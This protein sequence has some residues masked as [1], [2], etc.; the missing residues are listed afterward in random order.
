[1]AMPRAESRPNAAVRAEPRGIGTAGARDPLAREVKLLGALLGQV[2]V[3]QEGEELLE[4]VER[5]RRAAIALRRTDSAEDRRAL[6]AQLDAVDPRRTE[7]LIRAFGL[8][9]QL[10]N[11]AEEKERVRRLRRR[12]RRSPR[13]IV[14]GSVMDAMDRLRRAGISR[15]R[16]LASIESLSIALVLTAHP[17]EARRRTMLMALRRCYHLLEQLDDPRLTPV[18]DTE[19]RRQLRQEITLLW[20]TSPLRVQAVTPLDEVRSVMAFFDESLFVVTPRLYRVLDG[21]LDEAPESG[22]NR[23]PARDTGQTGTRPPRVVPFLEWGSWVGGDRDGNP[24]VTADITRQ[25]VRIQADHVLR[26]YE[27]VVHRLSQ[28]IAA[29]VPAERLP[30]AFLGHLSRAGS[31]LPAVAQDVAR[32]FPGEP[33]RQ[34]LV[35]LG[36]RLHRTR[37][38]IVDGTPGEGGFANVEE[39]LE[40]LDVLGDALLAQGLVRVAHGDLLALRWQVATFGFHALDLEIRQHSEVH[41]RALELLREPRSDPGAEASPGVPVS[42]V[43]ETFRAMSDIQRE[44]GERACH[45]YV[46]SF[47]RSARDVLDVLDLAAASA[48]PVALDLVPLFE[49][50]DALQASGAIVDELLAD[51]RYREHLAARGMHQEVMLGYSDS[52]KESGPLAAAWMLHRAQE[53]LVGVAQRHGV[54]LTLFHGRGG[55]I[56]RGGGP[57]SRAVMA[58]PP[59]SVAGRLKL[60]EQGEVIADRYANP[61]IALR[62]LEQ[63]TGAV[64]LASAPDHDERARAGLALGAELMDELAVASRRAYR[65]LV[66]ED[67]L[68]EPYFRTA[69]PIDELSGMAIGSRPAARAGDGARSLE[70]LRAIPWV[71]AWS[72]SRA[73]LPGWYGVGSA[74]AAY[75]EEHGEAGLARLRESYRSWPFLAG[76]IDT[77]E[78]SLAKA[79][80]QVARR[81]AGLAPSPGARRVWRRIRREFRL[82]HD[83]ILAV[84]GR[85]RIMDALPV[86]QRAIELRNPYVD[87]LSELQVRLL[88]R[89]RALEPGDAERADL[90]RLVYLTISGVAAGV[91]STG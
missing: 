8:Y 21:A 4:L 58:S 57:M 46:I 44:L 85:A 28:T 36:E 72:Q 68:F 10:A 54:Q 48:A 76:V 27:A 12:A 33:Y 19:V 11:L 55:A 35:L 51:R 53:Q 40:A 22:V 16:R 64:L 83:G 74:I 39:L 63:V 82:T 90:E 5:I 59:G 45:R 29:T 41:L 1:M 42:E 84:T 14:D 73:N 15:A 79:D 47:T 34:D 26:G 69:T 77:A 2:I 20:H 6:A 50:A 24:Y 80:M 37:L 70:Q 56:G 18:E 75:V 87:S 49:S 38:R 86:L 89:A 60:T 91:Q 7:V 66:W 61:A 31:Q 81:Y 62:H 78:M 43:L 52:T 32:R 17:T 3:E 13:G 67:P 88:A 65:A 23:G 9:F 30:G 25:A 71:F